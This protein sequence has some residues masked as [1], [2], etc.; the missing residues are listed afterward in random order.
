[1]LFQLIIGQHASY[2]LQ[3]IINLVL[4]RLRLIHH[5]FRHP[6]PLHWQ[7]EDHSVILGVL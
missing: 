5:R 2:L 3:A 4:E 6:L 1:M 7:L